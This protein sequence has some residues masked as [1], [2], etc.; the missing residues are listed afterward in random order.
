MK[1]MFTGT[2][3]L[4]VTGLA[5]LSASPVFAADLDTMDRKLAEIA[6]KQDSIL[7]QLAEIKAELQVVK[8]R[9][10]SS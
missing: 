7:Q 2:L 6:E 3:T 5:L 10:S 1:K 9:A 4:F 8:I